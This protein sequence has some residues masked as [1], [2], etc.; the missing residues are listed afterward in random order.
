MV[1]CVPFILAD[2]FRI[3]ACELLGIDPS[4]INQKVFGDAI[5]AAIENHGVQI[6]RD[7]LLHPVLGNVVIYRGI[8]IATLRI[9]WFWWNSKVLPGRVG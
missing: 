9:T 8:T 3:E 4:G 6:K 1:P 7:R 5:T 2:Q